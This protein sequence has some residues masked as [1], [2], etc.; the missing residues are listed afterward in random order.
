MFDRLGAEG[1]T[2]EETSAA[3][4]L[5][6][7]G[8]VHPRSGSQVKSIADDEAFSRALADIGNEDTG[9]ADFTP[10]GRGGIR[11]PDKRHAEKTE[12]GVDERD[13]LVETNPGV[14]GIELPLGMLRIAD[15]NPGAVDEVDFA[16]EAFD[17]AC[18]KVE[19]T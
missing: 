16:R 13:S 8:S 3:H 11:K 9:S 4:E 12:V 15:G 10:R 17:V 6:A 1:R 14:R 2:L 18:L 5:D 19:R 7:Q